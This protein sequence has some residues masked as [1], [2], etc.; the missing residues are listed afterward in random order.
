MTLPTG[1]PCQF[2]EESPKWPLAG[3]SAIVVGIGR[4]A[5]WPVNGFRH[6]FSALMQI[7]AASVLL[8]AA[9]S[10]EM[11]IPQFRDGTRPVGLSF[12]NPGI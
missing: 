4:L 7:P 9:G 6:R 3:V 12:G 10:H 1:R 11:R 8:A 5:A 2:P